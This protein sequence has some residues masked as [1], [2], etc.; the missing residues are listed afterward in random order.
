MLLTSYIRETHDNVDGS[1]LVAKQVQQ[2][3]SAA[4]R[5]GNMKM[6]VACVSGFIAKRLLC[7]VNCDACKACLTSQVMLSHNAFI[8]FKVYSDTKQSLTYP[9]EKLVGRNCRKICHSS[10]GYDGRCGSL[11]FSRTACP[12][13][14]QEQG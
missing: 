3:V 9:S 12:S 4:V 1:I 14:H 7:V 13:C 11:E 6:S 10:G 8:Y 5:A 2:Q